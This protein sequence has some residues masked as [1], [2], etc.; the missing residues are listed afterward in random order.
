MFLQIILALIAGILCGI[1]TGLVPGIHVNLI[2]VLLLSASSFLLNY[3]VGVVLAVFIISMAITHSFLDAIP[4]IFLGAPDTDTVMAVLPGHKLLLEGLGYDAV[5]LTVIGSLLCLI[6]G[7]ILTPLFVIIFPLIY[8]LVKDIM[9]FLLFGIVVFIIL[10][11]ETWKQRGFAVLVFSLSGVLGLVVLNSSMSQPLFAML[12][13]LFGTSTLF[14]SMFQKVSLPAQIDSEVIT[15]E[16]K[17]YVSSVLGGILSG[18]FVTIFPGLGPAQAASLSNVFFK[19]KEYS[20][21]VLVG[22][23]NTIGFLVSLVT[24]Y[25][26][27][28]ARNGA[29]IVV[30]NI[31]NSINLQKLILFSLVA[32]V[33]G[34]IA[35][36]LTLRIAKM[37]SNLVDKVNYNILGALVIFFIFILAFYFSGLIGILVLIIS[38]FIGV[39]PQL[40]ESS[41]SQAMGCILLPVILM[42]LV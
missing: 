34:G 4:S 23:I 33:V 26:I 17:D 36:I 9:G 40:T 28:K 1:V 41:R 39:I 18:S 13:G 42:Y 25:T 27:D 21:L 12:S 15:L 11:E 35:A 8:N 10:K 24:V 22:G 31:I 32:L 37:F 6:V 20:Y 14:I 5:R 29:V 3:T 38:T 2:S 19:A 16:K 7:I 30:M